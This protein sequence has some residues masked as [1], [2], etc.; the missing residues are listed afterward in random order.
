M[1]IEHILDKIAAG[2]WY[3][4]NADGAARP[5]QCPLEYRDTIGT[6]PV[7]KPPAGSAPP[8]AVLVSQLKA[9]IR[10]ELSLLPQFA[11]SDIGEEIV[12]GIAT[13]ILKHLPL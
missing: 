4:Q 8:N 12:G 5:P 7:A 13:E 10:A 6:T 9:L 11:A 1:P 2:G 3:N